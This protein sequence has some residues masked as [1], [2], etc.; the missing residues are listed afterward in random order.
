LLWEEVEV[1]LKVVVPLLLVDGSR[2]A[3]L[4]GRGGFL[5]AMLA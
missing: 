5:M 2:I 3:S 4:E 1:S